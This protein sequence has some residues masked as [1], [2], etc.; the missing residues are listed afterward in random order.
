MTDSPFQVGD[1]VS[2][3]HGRGTLVGR[4]VAL[5]GNVATVARGETAERGDGKRYKRFVAFL[6]KR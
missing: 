5:E 1:V 3:R 2:F 6:T 4:I